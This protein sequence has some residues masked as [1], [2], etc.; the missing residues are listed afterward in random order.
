M[1]LVPDPP[2]KGPSRFMEFGVTVLV[3]ESPYLSAT[4][5]FTG[6]LYHSSNVE[7]SHKNDQSCPSL[8]P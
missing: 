5:L 7:P 1:V 4:D 8:K 6:L 3:A 2:C